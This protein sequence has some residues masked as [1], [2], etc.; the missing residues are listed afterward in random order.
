M[1]ACYDSLNC[2][3]ICAGFCQDFEVVYVITNATSDSEFGF[4]YESS[5]ATSG[6]VSIAAELEPGSVICSTHLQS[7]QVSIPCDAESISESGW[8]LPCL[9]AQAAVCRSRACAEPVYMCILRRGS[10]LF[11]ET[12]MLHPIRCAGCGGLGVSTFT[13]EAA[14]LNDP[15]AMP[16]CQLGSARCKAAAPGAW[17]VSRS[18][19]QQIQAQEGQSLGGKEPAR[20]DHN[21]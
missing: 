18:R 15:T 17:S 13:G 2:L 1:T 19:L 10:R 9:L 16:G 21:L 12:P 5:H 4:L 20:G 8:K 14:A 3:V 7:T 11:L 6:A